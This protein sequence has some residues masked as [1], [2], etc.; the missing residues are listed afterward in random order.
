[1]ARLITD[2]NLT[3]H[4]DLYQALVAAQDGLDD[5]QSLE[6]LARLVLILVNHIGDPEVAHEAIALARRRPSSP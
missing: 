1:M 4:D 6:M 5:G 2:P 3:G